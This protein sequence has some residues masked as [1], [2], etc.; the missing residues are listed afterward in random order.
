MRCLRVNGTNEFYRKLV[1][2]CV[3]LIL[4]QKNF[5]P[6]EKIKVKIKQIQKEIHLRLLIDWK[7][8]E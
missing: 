5:I 6:N 2:L 8:M 7:I 4:R 1:H 3:I